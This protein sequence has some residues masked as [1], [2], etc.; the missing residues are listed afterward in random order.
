MCIFFTN[1]LFSALTVSSAPKDLRQNHAGSEEAES[2]ADLDSLDSTLSSWK[3][4]IAGV[5]EKSKLLSRFSTVA[6]QR[7]DRLLRGDVA[8]GAPELAFLLCPLFPTETFNRI[9]ACVIAALGVVGTED[10][11]TF[12][13]D[14]CWPVN[15]AGFLQVVAGTMALEDPHG[16]SVVA[17]EASASTRPGD[18][19][20][21][22]YS[23]SPSHATL[24]LLLLKIFENR[25]QPT[26]SEILWCNK[27]TTEGT[28]RGFL[29]RAQHHSHG[30][31]VLLQIDVLP[32]SVQHII[33]KLLLGRAH[34]EDGL[35]VE[36]NIHIV[37]TGPSMLQSASWFP[38]QSVEEYTEESFQ[39]AT[40]LLQSWVFDDDC[41]LEVDCYHGLPGSGKTHQMRKRL[42]ALASDP[43]VSSCIVSI[44]EAFTLGE[45]VRKL[46]AAALRFPGRK[47]TLF[48]HINLGKFKQEE[49]AQWTALM[50]SISK[51][52]IGMLVLRGLEDP[53]T[54]LTF[55]IP[56]GSKMRLMVELP[57]R[58]GHLEAADPR[59]AGDVFHCLLTE[60]P[61]LAA[62][63]RLVDAAERPFEVGE[64]ARHVSKYLKA[65]DDGSINQMYNSFNGKDVLIVLDVSGSMSGAPLETCKQCLLNDI[66]ATRFQ[67]EDR[68]GLI[69]F[70]S[71]IVVNEP[72]RSWSGAHRAC[73]TH[74]LHASRCSGGTLLWTAMAV[75]IQS[76]Q[77]VAAT[78]NQGRSQWIVAL[79]DGESWDH[80]DIVKLHLASSALSIGVLFIAVNLH[81]HYEQ[82]IR[83]AC[84]RSA[85]DVIFQ[86]GFHD[87]A[88]TWSDVGDRLTVSARIE[89]QAEDITTDECL[90][91]LQKYMHQP[92]WSRLKQQHWIRYLHRRCGILAA[93]EKFNL[94]KSMPELGSTTMTVMLEEVEHALADNYQV[95]WHSV[96]HEQFVYSR[97]RGPVGADGEAGEDSYRWSILATNA[98]SDDPAWRGRDKL[99]RSLGMQV[100]TRADLARQDR[101]VL[102]SYLGYGLGVPLQDVRAESSSA[103]GAFDFPL[104]SLRALDQ[105]QFVLTL[106]F[107]MKMLCINERLECRVPCI[108]EGETGVS[109]TALT[110]MLFNLKNTAQLSAP[111]P[112]SSSSSSSS[113]HEQGE[114]MNVPE[115]SA[116]LQAPTE[117]GVLQ[118]LAA[119]LSA[120]IPS[121]VNTA[122]AFA[123]ELLGIWDT[124]CFVI[125]ALRQDPSLDPPI[126]NELAEFVELT[127]YP[128]LT[129]SEFPT[130]TGPIPITMTIPKGALELLRWYTTSLI[131]APP[132]RDRQAAA[133]WTFYPVDVHA[134]LTP[135]EIAAQM[136]KV[137]ARAARLQLLGEVLASDAHRE[138]TLCIFFDEVNTSGCMGVFKELLIDHSLDGVPLPEN[139]IVVAACNPARAK[140]QLAGGRREELGNEW[141]MGHY[142]VHPLPSSLQQMTWDYGSLQPDQEWEFIQKK[143]L[144]LQSEQGLSDNET[145]TLAKLVHTSQQQTRESCKSHIATLLA[146]EQARTGCA[147]SEGEL[148]ARTSS[149][150]SL[151]DILMAFKL[152]SYLSSPSLPSAAAGVFLGNDSQSSNSQVQKRRR[153]MLLSIA[154]VYYLRLGNSNDNSDGGT[155]DYRVL[156][157]NSLTAAFGEVADVERLL[158]DRMNALL[159][160]TK[161]EPGIAKTQGLKENIFMVVVCCLAQVPLMIVGPPGS[162]KTL[163][164]TI[165]AE[166]AKGEYSRSPFYKALP[167]LIPFRYQC[168][169]KSTSVEIKAVFERAI[170]RQ[171]QSNA[172]HGNVRCFVFMDEAGLPEEERESLKILHYYLEDHMSV[173]A[174]VGFVAISNHL[175][176]AAKTNRCALLTHGKTDHEELMKIARGCLGTDAERRELVSTVPGLLRGKSVVL[177]LDPLE[178]RTGLLNL[179]CESFDNCMSEQ[180]RQRPVPPPADFV[181]F[182]GLRDFM[183]FI[184]LLGRQAKA[185]PSK[186]ITRSMIVHA[187]ERNL[188]GTEPH[189]LR[190]IIDYFLLPFTDSKRATPSSAL[191]SLSN[192]FDLL[193]QSL[194][195]QTAC[196]VAVINR[197]K[198]VIDTTADD[199]ILRALHRELSVVEAGSS[200]GS[201]EEVTDGDGED[202]SDS[203]QQFKVLKLSNFPEDTGVQQ[204]SILSQVKWAAEKGETVL[205]SQTEVINES[206]YDLFNQHFRRF[207]DKSKSGTAEVVY[208]TN[209]AV[210]AHSR[211]CKVDPN[212]NC[213]VHLTL[214]ELQLAPAP[215]LQRFEKYRIT[216][217]HLLESYLHHRCPL[218]HELP[219]LRE[220]LRSPVLVAHVKAF[221]QLIGVE[222][223]YGFADEQTIESGLLRLLQEWTSV[224]S[225]VQSI[226]RHFESVSFRSAIQAELWDLDLECDDLNDIFYIQSM[227]ACQPGNDEEMRIGKA[228]LGQSLLHDLSAQLLRV[229]VPER[230]FRDHGCVPE[231]LLRS[232]LASP[233]NFSLR[234]LLQATVKGSTARK[235]IVYT[236]TSAVVLELQ[237]GDAAAKSL[238]HRIV[239]GDADADAAGSSI[240]D[241]S[242]AL[243]SFSLLTREQQ[244]VEQLEAFRRSGDEVLLIFMDGT[245]TPAGQTNF[246][247]HLIDE[248]WTAL[249]DK[250]SVL[251]VLHVPSS[252]L[253]VH[254]CYCT[255]VCPDWTTT[256]LDSLEVEEAAGWLEL[257]AGLLSLT[258]EEHESW[259]ILPS[260]D[261]WL[262]AALRT[263]A[264]YVTLPTRC[265]EELLDTT[266]EDFAATTSVLERRYRYL[267]V[268]MDTP[269]DRDTTIR[270]LVLSRFAEIW[271]GDDGSYALLQELVWTRVRAL[272]AG[273]LQVSLREALTGEVRDMF[274]KFLAHMVCEIFDDSNATALLEL[275][276][277]SRKLQSEGKC[278]GYLEVSRRSGSGLSSRA[279]VAQEYIRALGDIT[280][281]ECRLVSTS[282]SIPMSDDTAAATAALFYDCLLRTP[283]P[284]LA[285]LAAPLR[286]MKVKES[287][288]PQPTDSV[289]PFFAKL[290]R[291][292]D[293]A[294]KHTV[295]RYENYEG[296]EN[297]WELMVDDVCTRIHVCSDEEADDE[298]S[299]SDPLAQVVA[300]HLLVEPLPEKTWQRYL[301][302]FIARLCPLPP[303]SEKNSPSPSTL[304]HQVL[305]M[306]LTSAVAAFKSQSKVASLHAVAEW[307]EGFLT[308]LVASLEPL[309]KLTQ[310]SEQKDIYDLFHGIVHLESDDD[311]VDGD[312]GG[313]RH[314]KL[315]NALVDAFYDSMH[316]ADL[317]QW[318]TA[319]AA[320]QLHA[321]PIATPGVNCRKLDA[322]VVVHAIA[323]SVG[324]ADAA[325]LFSWDGLRDS[326]SRPTT[327]VGQ[328]LRLSEVFPLLKEQVG[329]GAGDSCKPPLAANAA[330]LQSLVDIYGLT[331]TG[332]PE[333]R[334]ADLKCLI[335]HVLCSESL[336]TA[337][338]VPMLEG[339]PPTKSNPIHQ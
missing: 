184:R 313:S 72:P 326:L 121:S 171:A 26:S 178:N 56:P 112:S 132:D 163:A 293:V 182:F 38:V 260:L 84:V 253:L 174:Q 192:P 221:V 284:P 159:D 207:E 286:A 126:S 195:E 267:E 120:N 330:V 68:V 251:L 240:P 274:T 2:V 50:D 78:S 17:S 228:L 125:N 265:V 242:C 137:V 296:G 215:F 75:A 140:L 16:S 113:S 101:R 287:A 141:A 128:S 169:R 81:P 65:F 167:A 142:Q 290:S 323:R 114:V 129:S 292:M 27:A 33:V 204:V 231:S 95:D 91:L 67:P 170:E 320:S 1:N 29:E 180:Q 61:I 108:M 280:V 229:V 135:A 336:S 244:L 47:L 279:L 14:D 196:E 83:N 94:N 333:T 111:S 278:V 262:P 8:T 43:E 298:A 74:H 213:I 270:H 39:V 117:L 275:R 164:V 76:L 254:P 218:L 92:D 236:R 34:S 37:E 40:P 224:D 3:A 23:A 12:D 194:D 133:S 109:K 193:C 53:D 259:S 71:G 325:L 41:F 107:L 216:Q 288:T 130:G 266:D 206:F 334:V 77:S 138:T 6:A 134:A 4:V 86:A 93:S 70:S 97:E 198:M 241:I 46:A 283:S 5:M 13:A 299:F 143:L 281:E 161:L 127:I 291:I 257:G 321:I 211:R 322:M 48:M 208:H 191:L 308:S 157:K 64:E 149:S 315:N 295:L 124:L 122:E 212:F 312:G 316:C 119:V 145:S 202:A 269:L 222:S 175:L 201:A 25:P 155:C 15:A 162:S 237:A 22:R 303:Q 263:I 44:T 190:E 339:I 226:A 232:Y 187:L 304:Q 255:T 18:T 21:F 57:D 273:E 20:P 297:V 172:S 82:V 250:K 55:S 123:M 66:F 205:L 246:T 148:D 318:A 294:T 51:C 31:F 268:A 87:L 30:R 234:A 19:G 319:F 261:S 158:A 249:S 307:N 306:W 220:L 7:M 146:A 156:F 160:Q 96:N 35:R 185:D 209:I 214:P 177:N 90:H 103:G 337:K 28:V 324:G 151:R 276:R 166:N 277:D 63:A 176:D 239:N 131:S 329:A 144:Y 150:V 42:D 139:V 252:D 10:E 88:Q 147:I 58:S 69:T 314:A 153:A 199:S 302:S 98:D 36:H 223:F 9:L 332:R 152:F 116:M 62:V 300:R 245:Q 219:V 282:I 168:S 85:T 309:A 45:V 317:D 188:N 118:N 210:G 11:G 301:D 200:G 60:I 233:E 115:V 80:P 271:A 331:S 32:R 311:D 186:S 256:F 335:E 105:K 24:L 49:T 289:L 173:A 189:M 154:V 217:T 136:E 305:K 272:A 183:H 235:Q 110:R 100:P 248:R 264:R 225:V 52:L 310:G 203:K 106:D 230:L 73:L 258:G 327:A 338:R 59:I 285:E 243:L 247:R 227:L 328:R 104:G 54:G 165:I 197:Y 99:L 238:L 89:K 79:T 181:T 102:D 179:L